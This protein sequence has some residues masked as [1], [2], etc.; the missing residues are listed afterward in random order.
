MCFNWICCCPCDLSH[1]WTNRIL[2]DILHATYKTS[3]CTFPRP[4]ERALLRDLPWREVFLEVTRGG[5]NQWCS[6]HIIEFP[7]ARK[8]AGTQTNSALTIV[9]NHY[10]HYTFT[11]DC[12]AN[13]MFLSAASNLLWYLLVFSVILL[14]LNFVLLILSTSLTGKERSINF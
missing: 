3:N 6:S 10:F 1:I 8:E 9:R 11:L 2:W 14:F 7:P 5:G 4:S 13:L 12:G